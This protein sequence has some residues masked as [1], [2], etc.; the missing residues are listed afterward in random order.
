MEAPIR[1]IDLRLALRLILESGDGKDLE[2]VET[3]LCADLLIESSKNMFLPLLSACMNGPI[4]N[5][6]PSDGNVRFEMHRIRT[7]IASPRV[8]VIRELSI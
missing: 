5:L 1:K 8:I 3:Q 4:S 2:A 7:P 6:H